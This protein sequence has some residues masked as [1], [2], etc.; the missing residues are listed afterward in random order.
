MQRLRST[1]LALAGG[2]LLVALSISAAFGADPTE[3]GPNRG[4]QVS[5]F[6]HELIF[7]SDPE[8]EEEPELEEDQD[9]GAE[10]EDDP[11]E[12]E[13]AEPLTGGEHGACVSAV[14]RDRTAIGGPN[15]NHGGAVSE[16]AR[17]TCWDATEDED[18]ATAEDEATDESLTDKEQRKA[19]RDAAKAESRA[20]REA[21]KAARENG[22]GGGNGRP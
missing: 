17:E 5:A 11:E 4:Q 3:A 9:S 14:A 12:S 16:A 18:E 13:E 7:G 6:V 15:E 1:W 20:E 21:A 10:L 2:G 8:T 19:E 22:N